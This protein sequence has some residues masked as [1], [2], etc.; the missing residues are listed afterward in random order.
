MASYVHSF[1][2]SSGVCW[3][4]LVVPNK[5]ATWFEIFLM[6]EVK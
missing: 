6:N 3:E 1:I 2:R 5:L 4:P